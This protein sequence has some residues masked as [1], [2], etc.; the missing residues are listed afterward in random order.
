[1]LC[2]KLICHIPSGNNRV[3]TCTGVLIA[4]LL[5][6][7]ACACER[8]SPPELPDPDSAVTAQMIKAKNEMQA[9]MEAANRYLDCIAKDT[10]QYN[11]WVDEMQEAADEFNR[12][13]RKYKKRMTSS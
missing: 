6:A 13:V 7:P 1:M 4:V 8:P 12:I 9:F 2:D 10:S 3:S 5:S 11:A